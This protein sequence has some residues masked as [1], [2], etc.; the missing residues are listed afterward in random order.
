MYR[1]FRLLSN[2]NVLTTG[3]LSPLMLLTPTFTHICFRDL[4]CDNGLFR[5]MVTCTRA[6]SLS[7]SILLTER[8]LCF[9][10]SSKPPIFCTTKH[11][12][13]M[14]KTVLFCVSCSL[15]SHGNCYYSNIEYPQIPTGTSKLWMLDFSHDS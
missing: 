5:L 7:V 6:S 8:T 10:T 4:V 15:C 2:G 3:I 13:N 1:A 14:I 11:E 9:V 12:F